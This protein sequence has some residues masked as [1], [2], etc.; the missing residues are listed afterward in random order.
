MRKKG[1]QNRTV[2][3]SGFANR[4]SFYC[5][6]LIIVIFCSNSGNSRH[7]RTASA[8][9]SSS[10][11]S[12]WSAGH[13]DVLLGNLFEESLRELIKCNGTSGNEYLFSRNLCEKDLLKQ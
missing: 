4:R 10:V 1:G 8:L 9:S 7:R 3:T 12:V 11:V 13:I 6:F 5:F 2:K